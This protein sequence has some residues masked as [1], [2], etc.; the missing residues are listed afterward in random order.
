MVACD[1]IQRILQILEVS[2]ATVVTF[3][4]KRSNNRVYQLMSSDR[5]N[6]TKRIVYVLR[7]VIEFLL[8]NKWIA[9]TEKG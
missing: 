1:G 6:R 4:T 9:T 5:G 7:C 3:H 2:T 8:N